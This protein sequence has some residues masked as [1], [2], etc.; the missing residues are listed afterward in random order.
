MTTTT[1]EYKGKTIPVHYGTPLCADSVHRL[2]LIFADLTV[3]AIP[4]DADIAYGLA[5]WSAHYA[6]DLSRAKA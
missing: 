2:M 1:S 4:H 3:R 6:S 5:V